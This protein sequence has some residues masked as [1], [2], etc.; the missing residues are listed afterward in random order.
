VSEP[1]ECPDCGA[2]LDEI[3]CE[4]TV[5][6]DECGEEWKYASGMESLERVE[7]NDPIYWDR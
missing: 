2:E 3:G 1:L 4:K 7:A 6:C 5:T